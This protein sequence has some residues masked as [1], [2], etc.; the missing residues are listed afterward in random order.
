MSAKV[1]PCPHC[2][3]QPS[4]ETCE[5][6]PAKA[7]PPPWHAGCYRGGSNEH[8][9]GGNGDTKAEAIAVWNREVAALSLSQQ[10]TE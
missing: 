2:G 8:Y 5:P 1:L 9:V 4:I 10:S 6:W 3:A 7:G